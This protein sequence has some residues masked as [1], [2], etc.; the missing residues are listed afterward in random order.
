MRCWG[1]LKSLRAQSV[2]EDGAYWSC[3]QFSEYLEMK[4][5]QAYNL[6]KSWLRP[7]QTIDF[8]LRN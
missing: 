4:V 7:W 1:E 5:S 3:V 6:S 2:G 8:L